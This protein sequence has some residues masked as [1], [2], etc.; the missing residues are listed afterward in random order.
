MGPLPETSLIITAH[1]HGHMLEK[2]LDAVAALDPAP[3]EALAKSAQRC[4][5]E[6]IVLPNAPSVTA[7]LRAGG[8]GYASRYV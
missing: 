8:S 7:F 6:T 3:G 1:R 5:F 4:G 2:C